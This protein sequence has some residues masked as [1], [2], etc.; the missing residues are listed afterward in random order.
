MRPFV[1]VIALIGQLQWLPGSFVC[2][3]QQAAADPCAVTMPSG[4]SVGVPSAP[5]H[6]TASCAATGPCAVVAPA[7][8]TSPVS[9][10]VGEVVRLV[11]LPAHT[12][13]SGFVA[14]PLSPPPQA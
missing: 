14:P 13:L 1:A 8:V 12:R 4:P 10:F 11:L 9:A 7:V 6:G 3:R 5:A 2:M